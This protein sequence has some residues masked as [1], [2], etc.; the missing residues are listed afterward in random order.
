MM[1]S[2]VVNHETIPTVIRR[3]TEIPGPR[4]RE[5]MARRQ[6]AV[7]RS[8]YNVTPIFV[9]RGAGAIIEDVDGN[10]YI[11]FAGGIGCLNVGS[12]QPAV[13]KAVQQQASEFFHAGFPVAPY[14]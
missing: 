8:A 12:A 14:E 1:M 3:V 9:R 11:D 6:A 10:T 2:D 5:L 7:P 13:V 4:S